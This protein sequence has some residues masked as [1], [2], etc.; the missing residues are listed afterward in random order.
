[1]TPH[2]RR[3]SIWQY[4]PLVTQNVFHFRNPDEDENSVPALILAADLPEL[5]F[6]I[7][8]NIKTAEDRVRY[9]RISPTAIDSLTYKVASLIDQGRLAVYLRDT[10]MRVDE[11]TPEHESD[12]FLVRLDDVERICSTEGIEISHNIATGRATIDYSQIAEFIGQD[13]LVDDPLFTNFSENNH[14]LK[15]ESNISQEEQI[16]NTLDFAKKVSFEKSRTTA[17]ARATAEEDDD[18]PLGT[19][20]RNNVFRAFAGVC[21]I[22]GIDYNHASA[23]AATIVKKTQLRGQTVCETT[24]EKMLKE[25]PKALRKKPKPKKTRVAADDT[26]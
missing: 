11:Y 10:R 24:I 23:A 17:E 14:S 18:K 7:I 4:I 20:E 21:D 3:G 22:A 16:F 25:I 19:R 26:E 15:Y 5:L 8:Y 2:T 12:V 13:D 6:S 9:Q 1:M